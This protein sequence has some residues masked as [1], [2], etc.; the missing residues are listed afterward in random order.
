M[1]INRLTSLALGAGLL[2]VH[3]PTFA[4][5]GTGISY[6]LSVPPI[7]TKAVVTEFHWSN[8]HLGIFVNIEDQDGN[9]ENWGIEGSSPGRM[10][11]AG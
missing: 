11:R 9:V 1:K 10:A 3:L 5:H 2:I 6:N 7:T 8:P 4:H